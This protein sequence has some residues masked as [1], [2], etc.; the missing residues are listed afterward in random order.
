MLVRL[1]PIPNVAVNLVILVAVG[2]RVWARRQPPTTP[3]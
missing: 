2:T 1:L 3:V